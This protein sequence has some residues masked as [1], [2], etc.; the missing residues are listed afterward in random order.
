MRAHPAGPRHAEVHT[1]GSTAGTPPS[2]AEEMRHLEPEVWPRGAARGDDGVV[3]LAGVDVR[4]L[5]ETYGTPLFVIDEADF[6]SRC[7]EYMKAFTDPAL[8]H[9]AGKAFLSVQA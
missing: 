8:V 5:A 3:R 9:Y 4:E 2:T 7:R 6:R 1:S